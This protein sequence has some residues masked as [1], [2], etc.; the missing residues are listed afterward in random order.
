MTLFKTLQALAQSAIELPNAIHACVEMAR[1]SSAYAR[2]QSPGKRAL[3]D[4]SMMAAANEERISSLRDR[5]SA[6][7]ER[8]ARW[9][10]WASLQFAVGQTLTD[11]ELREKISCEID[12]LIEHERDKLSAQESELARLREFLRFRKQSAERC[13]FSDDEIV[14][15]KLPEGGEFTCPAGQLEGIDEWRYARLEDVPQ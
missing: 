1:E 6:A 13:P 3:S 9:E 11:E 2:E 12:K 8:L 5:L 10:L 15:C 4:M 7:N 14:I